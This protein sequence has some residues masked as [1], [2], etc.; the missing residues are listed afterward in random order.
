MRRTLTDGP[1]GTEFWLELANFKRSAWRFEQQPA[2]FIGYEH[3]QFDDFLA[4]HPEPPTANP[5]LRD[6]MDQVARQVS[7]GK[8]IGRVRI[9]DEPITDYQRWMRWMDRW[10]REAGETIDYLTRDRACQVKLLPAAGKQD[11]WLFDDERLMVMYFDE[12]WFR[13]KVELV[14]DEPEVAKAREFRDLAIRAAR[15]ESRA[16]A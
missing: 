11:W 7:E 4:G 2:Y 10:N 8:T 15:E 16:T 13:S 6:W 3:Q 5:D 14:V 9:V 12:K 1:P